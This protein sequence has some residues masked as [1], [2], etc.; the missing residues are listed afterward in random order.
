MDFRFAVDPRSMLAFAGP[1]TSEVEESNPA[2]E[3]RHVGAVA[4]QRRTTT[5]RHMPEPQTPEQLLMKSFAGNHP[6]CARCGAAA[7]PAV[8]M[9]GEWGDKEWL[10]SQEQAS[11]WSCFMQA[12]GEVVNAS[13][14][15]KCV[16][17]EIGA[18][19]RVPTVRQTSEQIL[20]V[21]LNGGA[22]AKLIR[23]NPQNPEPDDPD[24]SEEILS[25]KGTGLDF[26]QAV[27]AL[28]P[29]VP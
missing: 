19:G 8:L 25:I 9:F 3:M 11:R 15:L 26:L 4:G 13:P 2:P 12:L 23:V 7:R 14:G 22:N 1:A 17:L 6:K 28:L 24:L 21:L 5:L 27:D 20:E 16:L 18:G 29:V 10:D